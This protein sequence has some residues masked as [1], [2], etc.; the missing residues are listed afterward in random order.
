MK[1]VSFKVSKEDQKIISQIV[2][3][4]LEMAAKYNI[5]YDRITAEMDI[6]ACHASGCPLDL[7]ALL[8]ADDYNFA[9]DVFGIRKDLNRDTG[10]LINCFLPRFSK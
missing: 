3:R 2:Q 10:E 9:H 5:D 1:T 4:T 8:K 6:T 7:A